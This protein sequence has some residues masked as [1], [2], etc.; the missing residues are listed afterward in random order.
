MCLRAVGN[1]SPRQGGSGLAVRGAHAPDRP[2]QRERASI[3][4]AERPGDCLGGDRN[5]VVFLGLRSTTSTQKKTSNRIDGNKR[6]GL[7]TQGSL[8]P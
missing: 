1:E 6:A 5:E 8:R 3:C 7:G 4:R 2:A